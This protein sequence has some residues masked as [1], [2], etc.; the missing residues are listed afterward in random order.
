L[1]KY[2]R[3]THLYSALLERLR[4]NSEDGR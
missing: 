2:R 3:Q 4:H 1:I